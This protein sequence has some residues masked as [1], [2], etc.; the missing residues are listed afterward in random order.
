MRIVLQR[1]LSTVSPVSGG[2]RVTVQRSNVPG[3]IGPQGPRGLPGAGLAEATGLIGDGSTTSFTINHN[4]NT[5]DVA[6]EVFEVATGLTI[7]PTVRRTDEDN[8]VISFKAEWTPTL[9]QY[10]YIIRASIET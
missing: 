8:V 5:S 2:A 3:P 6:V 10:R 1:S 7:F 4:F 9:N